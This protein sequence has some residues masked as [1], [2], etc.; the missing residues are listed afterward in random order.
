M[1]HGIP[2]T[3]PVD[4]S[5]VN[6]PAP[7]DLSIELGHHGDD[8]AATVASDG[9]GETTPESRR[10]A[11]RLLSAFSG[12][13]LDRL[14]TADGLVN[15]EEHEHA[16]AFTALSGGTS[17][18]DRV[19]MGDASAPL[20]AG[21]A[22]RS[23]ASRLATAAAA[24]N[25]TKIAWAGRTRFELQ[26]DDGV[27]LRRQVLEWT[28]PQP[29][30]EPASEVREIA[31]AAPRYHLP[32]PPTVAVRGL[33]RSLRQRATKL[34]SPDEQLQVRWPSQMLTAP[35][36]TDLATVLPAVPTGALPPEV[37]PLSR[38][39]LLLNPY[40]APWLARVTA[41]APAAR[42]QGVD[43]KAIQARFLAESALRYGAQATYTGRAAFLG[44]D[45]GEL[46]A[47]QV[48]DQLRRYSVYQ[49]VE[50][51]PVAV[52]AW[53]QPW[54]PIWLEWEVAIT[55]TDDLAAW[56]LGQIDLEP[57]DPVTPTGL[58][59]SATGRSVLTTG[60]ATTM[61]A[62]ITDWLAAEEARDVTGTG[63]LDPADQ[64]ALA[65]LRSRLDT[66]DVLSVVLDGLGDQLLGVPYLD[67]RTSQP[68]PDDSVPELL[69]RG[70]L[71]L[72]RAR[73]IDAFGQVVDL[74]DASAPGLPPSTRSTRRRPPCESGPG[75][76]CPPGGCSGSSTRPDPR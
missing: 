29:L 56:S 35:S 57:P 27:A 6:Q 69:L 55:E 3:G 30:S 42:A 33:K 12:H 72:V 22:G 36:L 64:D 26:P 75:S 25:E 37:V 54:Q 41:D 16:S 71:R 18:T 46:T 40:L 73:L 74:P 11:E 14:A 48:A 20:T 28:A 32:T 38:E 4:P 58:V 66:F 21:G 24:L 7:A 50:P 19:K 53:S 31:R 47:I 65:S 15:V 23:T 34:F 70:E 10:A 63:E 44:S 61:A 62:A 51:S 45:V 39:A 49:G 1:V 13:L 52:T 17:G 59:L 60:V 68:V 76:P 9:F 5:L 43:G 8:V 67:G 2:F